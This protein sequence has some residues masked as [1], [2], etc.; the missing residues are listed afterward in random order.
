ME[1]TFLYV[2]LNYSKL[3]FIIHLARVSF[4]CSLQSLFHFTFSYSISLKYVYII[5]FTINP[6]CTCLF[7]LF[8]FR[9]QLLHFTFSFS[10]FI[11]IFIFIF[12]SMKYMCICQYNTKLIQNSHTQYNHLI[13][14]FDKKNLQF[15]G[16]CSI[17]R[18][19]KK[20]RGNNILI[21]PL[22][23]SICI[24]FYLI[25]FL[26][27]IILV[28][29]FIVVV[30]ATCNDKKYRLNELTWNEHDRSQLELHG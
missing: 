28:V 21:T 7:L 26:K 27:F 3:I 6:I 16:C 5:F 25:F 17:V 19:R 30:L 12:I 1:I 4:I 14:M 11:A 29:G 10:F 15:C 9:S 22:H 8:S 13:Y 18:R 24:P 20:L 23:V 2:I